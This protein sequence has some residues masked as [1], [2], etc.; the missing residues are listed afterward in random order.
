M[1]DEAYTGRVIGGGLLAHNPWP[2]RT[3]EMPTQAHRIRLSNHHNHE[4]QGN[5]G[6]HWYCV[7]LAS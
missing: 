5:Q 4:N 6:N 7:G 3:L 2:L 1:M